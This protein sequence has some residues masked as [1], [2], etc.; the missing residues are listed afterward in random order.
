LCFPFANSQPDLERIPQAHHHAAVPT[1]GRPLVQE[2]RAGVD[3][4]VRRAEIARVGQVIE[5]GAELQVWPSVT[6]VFLMI[7]KYRLAIPSARKEHECL[8]GFHV[9]SCA[10]S[11]YE[12]PIW[13]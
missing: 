9:L 2:I 8:H 11:K 1:V 5:L 10:S 12:S 7:P 6:L 3:Q 4:R 13:Q